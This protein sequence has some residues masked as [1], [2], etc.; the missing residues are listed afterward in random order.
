MTEYTF[1]TVMFGVSRALGICAQL[2][3]HR[4]VNSPIVRPKS[5]T[6]DELEAMAQRATVNA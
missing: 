3:F 2:L 4:M 6:L 5:V 1:Y